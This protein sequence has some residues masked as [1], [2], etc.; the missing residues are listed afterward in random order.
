[1]AKAKQGDM[2]SCAECGLVVLVDEV[3]GYAEVAV[4]C[5]KKPMAIGKSAASKAKKKAAPKAVTT[6]AVKAVA[7]AKGKAAA[8]VPVKAA[9]PAPKKP[10]KAAKK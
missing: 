7:P 3:S 9:K 4:V 2:L 10:A 5:C 6:K 1:M 8:K